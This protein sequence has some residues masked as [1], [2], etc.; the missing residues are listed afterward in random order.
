MVK[1]SGLLNYFFKANLLFLLNYISLLVKP[2]QNN[3]INFFKK[4]L[5][6]NLI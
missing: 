1:V 4:S 6:N 5:I 3:I 2:N